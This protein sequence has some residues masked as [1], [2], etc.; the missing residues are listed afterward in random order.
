MINEEKVR[1]MTKLAIYEENKGKHISPI[2]DY[3]K[4]DYV[5]IQMLKS[6]F[7]GTFAYLLIL[8]LMACYQL[9]YLIMEIVKLDVVA[10]IISIVVAYVFF[11]AVYL[12]IT[13]VICSTKYKKAKKS[14]KSYDNVLKKLEN[15]YQKEE[16]DTKPI[17]W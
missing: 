16:D 15:V 11:M 6:F 13:Y 10:M 8:L 17:K 2:G 5:G 9:E 1:L 4:E 3:Y 7:A 12:G 14:L